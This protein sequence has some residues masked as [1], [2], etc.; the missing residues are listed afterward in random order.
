ME[1]YSYSESDTKDIAS[2]IGRNLEKGSTLCLHGDLGVG[3]TVF[4]RGLTEALGIRDSVS[5]PSFPILQI[6]EGGRLPVYHIDA[7][8]IEE[9]EEMEEVGD[10]AMFEDGITLIEWPE[11]IPSYLPEDAIHIYIQK[12]LSMGNNYR[13]ITVEGLLLPEGGDE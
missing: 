6:Y 7:Y 4:V 3:K 10:A 13:I 5:S 12:D 1:V 9:E 11:H 8:R 2:V